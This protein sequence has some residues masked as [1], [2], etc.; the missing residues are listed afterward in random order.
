MKNKLNLL[1]LFAFVFT[2][3]TSV[4][5]TK[6]GGFVGYGSSRQQAGLG[7]I[8]EF[9]VSDK[10]SLSPSLLFYF[11]ESTNTFRYNWLEFNT[12]VNYYFF[13]QGAINVYGIGGMNY[14]NQ[15]VKN[16]DTGSSSSHGDVGVNLGVGSYFNV[17]K[18]FY[19]FAELKFVLGDAD[20][21]ALF[22]GVKT[23]IRRR[24]HK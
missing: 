7:T 5:Q 22:F 3:S 16:K 12:N 18:N 24:A 23:N 8:A 1:V 9:P 4:A 15:H 10:V 20:Q 21:M 13:Q 17:N 14:F 11:P 19:P 2:L 6:V